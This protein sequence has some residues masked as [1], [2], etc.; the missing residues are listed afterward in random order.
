MA[1]LATDDVRHDSNC[2]ADEV[3]VDFPSVAHAVERMRRA[4]VADERPG[5]LHAAVELTAGEAAS[6]V[7]L[8]L[9]V[10][11]Y[12]TCPTCGGRGETWTEPCPQCEGRGS[13]ALTHPVQV[14]MPA[15]VRH[16]AR[17]RFSLT[18]RHHQPT[19]IELHVIVAPGR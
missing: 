15:G 18:P 8:P 17:F 6:G 2:F 4:F 10:P 11:V 7:T 5:T 13:A 9:D 1:V 14:T 12:C 16:G 19:R 3:S